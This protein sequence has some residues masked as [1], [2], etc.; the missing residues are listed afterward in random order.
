MCCRAVIA[1]QV[2]RRPF[3]GD[4]RRAGLPALHEPAG[5][6]GVETSGRCGARETRI[7]ERNRPGSVRPEIPCLTS[8]SSLFHE[9]VAEAASATGATCPNP[10]LNAAPT[11]DSLWS[12]QEPA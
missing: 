7:A 3:V 2:L 4:G 11:I 9:A 12:A 10:R 5:A 8:A 6:G 1:D